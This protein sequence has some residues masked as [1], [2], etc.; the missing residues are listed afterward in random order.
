MNR[1]L[2]TLLIGL[3]STSLLFA[4]NAP[5]KDQ[6]ETN[7]LNVTA[8]RMEILLESAEGRVI[9][10]TDNV[11][12]EDNAMTLTADRMKIFLAEEKKNDKAT[13]TA[14]KDDAKKD[15]EKKDD[16]KK[17]DEKKDNTSM[18]LKRIEAYGNVLLRKKI[19]VNDSAAGSQAVYDTDKD[20]VTLSGDCVIRQQGHTMKGKEVLFDR[21]QQKITV[22]GAEV[23]IQLRKGQNKGLGDLL[24]NK[25]DDKDEAAKDNADKTAEPKAEAPQQDEPKPEDVKQEEANPEAP[26]AEEPKPVEAKQEEPKQEEAKPV[27]V[28]QEEPKQEEPKKEEPQPKRK[29]RGFLW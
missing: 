1:H 12:F 7:E 3:L 8:E 26:K 17:D 2:A 29:K 22:K 5:D 6:E 21:K 25:K 14:Q 24:G 23:K 16:E 9:E 15:D 19:D 11:R 27:E 10:L 18:T 13:D 4:Q 28:K 20:V